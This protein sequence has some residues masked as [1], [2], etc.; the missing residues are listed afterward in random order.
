M[1]FHLCS[2]RASERALAFCVVLDT[3]EFWRKPYIQQ[4][5]SLPMMFSLARLFARACDRFGVEGKMAT[6]FGMMMASRGLCGFCSL[7]CVVLV[8][9]FRVY[10]FLRICVVVGYE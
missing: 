6:G 4:P 7:Y 2:E 10:C 8:Y 5:Y 3:K 9:Y 1:T